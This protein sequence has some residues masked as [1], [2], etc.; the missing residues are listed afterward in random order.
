MTTVGYGDVYSISIYGRIVSTLNAVWGTF[1]IS[2]LV[3]AM[4][5]IF[6]IG[7]S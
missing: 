5:R 3:A 7:E 2:L 1:I 4:S 6:Q